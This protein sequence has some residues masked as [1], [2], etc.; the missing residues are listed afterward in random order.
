MQTFLV[1]LIKVRQV[2]AQYLMYKY[3]LILYAGKDDEFSVAFPCSVIYDTLVASSAV[4][5][6]SSW[7][8]SLY[9]LIFFFSKVIVSNL[10]D[11]TI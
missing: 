2:E 5:P 6:W 11:I 8:N 10:E 3:I 4:L 9:L 7:E 1:V